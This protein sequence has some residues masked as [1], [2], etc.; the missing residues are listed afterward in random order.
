MPRNRITSILS[1]RLG[2]LALKGLEVS[3]VGTR[4]KL[5]WVRENWG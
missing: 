4:W 3:T 5:M 1:S 2:I